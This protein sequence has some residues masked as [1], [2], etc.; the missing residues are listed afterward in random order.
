M[1]ELFFKRPA[2]SGLLILTTLGNL[3]CVN[4]EYDLSQ[5]IDMDMTLLQNTSIPLGNVAEISIN[6]LLGE[7]SESSVFRTDKNGNLSL[8][9]GSDVLTKTFKMP[10]VELGGDGGMNFDENLEVI[11]VP[12]YGGHSLKGLKYEDISKLPNIP[13]LIHFST[14]NGNKVERQFEVE[15]HK[16]LPKQIEDIDYVNLDAK[17]KY[18]FSASSGAIMHINKDFQIE[19]PSFMHLADCVGTDG[20]YEVKNGVVTFLK[21]TKITSDSPFEL[22]LDF[23]KMD[24]PKGS[25]IEE[26]DADGNINKLVDIKDAVIK[27]SGDLYI[28]P[29]DYVEVC[30][31]NSDLV[32]S[33][34]I[35]LDNLVMQS[36]HVKL[37]MDIQI[38]DKKIAIGALP[39]I[40]NSE[41]TVVDLYNPIF[42]IR[43]D[44]DSALEMNLNAGITSYSGKHTTDI[45]IGDYCINGDEGT[46]K[47]TIP[48]EGEEE[49]F[50]SR[51]GK[52][53]SK[54]GQDIE[55]EHLGDIISETPD[56]III[57]DIRVEAE[58]KFI[59]INANEE[60]L[61]H[62]EY[63]FFSPL[64][65]GKDLKLSFS[66][67]ID[68]GISDDTIGLDSL[69]LSMNMLNSIP[70]DFKIKGVAL[71]DEGNELK[72]VSVDMDMSLSAGTLDEP[73]PSPVD[74]ILSAN[75]SKFAISKLR[76]LLTAN[77]P[78]DS[79]L[80]GN[81]LNASQGLKINDVSITLPQ[82]ITLD[83][84]NNDAE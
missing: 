3:S 72:K 2:I 56:S 80:V 79:E 12:K 42:R 15:L 70:L 38:E 33:M 64:A 61:V 11:F 40:F 23:V 10:E 45:H 69:V 81:A 24:I 32:L 67:D 62:M 8:S 35:E 60:H 43:V 63:E 41:G 50:F 55:L 59:T 34:D 30:I 25:V 27:A 37:D 22:N 51:R 39:E 13:D 16:A 47:V 53:D 54:E 66:Y 17:I 49:Y 71:D 36:A 73:V 46:S 57:H 84:T 6:N 48:S 7:I 18:I 58:D 21:D 9:F 5:G 82:G 77:A 44:N 52:H 1:N 76:L 26:K 65:F 28:K 20:V 74:V 19:F 83:L 75:R 78:K 68:L 29:A 14:N 4:E 31:P